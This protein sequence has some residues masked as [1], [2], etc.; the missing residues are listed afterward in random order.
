[1]GSETLVRLSQGILHLTPGGVLMIAVGG[2]L[3]YL[4]IEKDYEPMLLLPIGAGCIVSQVHLVT[5]NR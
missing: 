2:V 1:M 3:L 5:L 4:A